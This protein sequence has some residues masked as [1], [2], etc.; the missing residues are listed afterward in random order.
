MGFL[1]RPYSR[2]QRNRRFLMKLSRRGTPLASLSNEAYAGLSNSF[3]NGAMYYHM[4][5]H[6]IRNCAKSA[7][8]MMQKVCSKKECLV[9]LSSKGADLLHGTAYRRIG[10]SKP[11]SVS[12]VAFDEVSFVRAWWTC[13][14]S[15]IE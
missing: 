6:H 12:A 13:L 1:I 10:E 3:L 4:I 14:N 5:R 11:D 8:S 15:I 9:V 2:L 7:Q